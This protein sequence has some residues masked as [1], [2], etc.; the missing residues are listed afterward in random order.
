MGLCVKSHLVSEITFIISSSVTSDLCDVSM[1]QW[2]GYNEIMVDNQFAR[3]G[4]QLY[5]ETD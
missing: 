1:M 3:H 5:V 2:L 4:T